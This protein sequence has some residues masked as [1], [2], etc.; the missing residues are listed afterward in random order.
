MNPSHDEV[1]DAL[2]AAAEHG[3][4][5]VIKALIEI[6][7]GD[8]NV[9]DIVHARTGETPLQ[10]A[11]RNGKLDVVRVLLAAGFPLGEERKSA[12][13]IKDLDKEKVAKCSAYTIACEQKQSKMMDI[14]HQFFIQKVAEND[15]DAV[16]RLLEAG[17]DVTI[18]GEDTNAN[19]VYH[20]AAMCGSSETLAVLLDADA[21]KH[22][23]D[24]P[25]N[26]GATPLTEAVR[27]DHYECAKLLLGNGAITNSISDINPVEVDSSLHSERMRNLFSHYTKEHEN[28]KSNQ[29]QRVENVA[30]K[31]AVK[32]PIVPDN[33]FKNAMEL[34]EKDL[35]IGQLKSTIERLVGELR[36]L[37]SLGRETSVLEYIRKLRKEKEW[38]NYRLEDAMEQIKDQQNQIEALK[39]HVRDLDLWRTKHTTQENGSLSFTQPL[40]HECDLK[41]TPS[42]TYAKNSTSE[43]DFSRSDSRL[44]LPPRTSDAAR[45]MDTTKSTAVWSKVLPSKWNAEF[46]DEIIITV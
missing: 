5:D 17:I 38:I 3:R 39:E 11:L 6:S 14:F 26:Q 36:D 35:L 20:W 32:H 2:F 46:D 18:T 16:R 8:I 31:V 23:F 19:S 12:V 43:P 37:E 10:V 44:Y 1:H 45:L 42:T 33:S 7:E 22:W 27:L 4:S 28:Q 40:T 34:E 24:R 13:E 29:N 30:E 15:V 21:E 25:N 41:K 9:R